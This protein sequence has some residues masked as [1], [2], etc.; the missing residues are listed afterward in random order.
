LVPVCIWTTKH[1][2]EMWL[3]PQINRQSLYTFGQSLMTCMYSSPHATCLCMPKYKQ[4]MSVY[5]QAISLSVC[6]QALF[7][8]ECTL[9]MDACIHIGMFIYRHSLNMVP[10]ISIVLPSCFGTSHSIVI[11]HRNISV[12]KIF[13]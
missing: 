5:K 2:D 11:C 6:I 7:L 1:M 10:K 13:F 4:A 3:L 12:L 9:L 8:N